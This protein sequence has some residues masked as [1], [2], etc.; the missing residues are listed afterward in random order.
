MGMINFL[1]KN[2][3][4]NGKNSDKDSAG[5]V[6]LPEPLRGRVTHVCL[7]PLYLIH[8]TCNLAQVNYSKDNDFFY[9]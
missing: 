8:L 5:E 1:E 4:G 2:P 6:V 9:I 3:G 7:Q